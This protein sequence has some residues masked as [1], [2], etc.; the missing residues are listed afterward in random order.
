MFK[1][2]LF[3]HGEVKVLLNYL[4]N[5]VQEIKQKGKYK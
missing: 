1:Y 2:D 5:I 4:S 3:S